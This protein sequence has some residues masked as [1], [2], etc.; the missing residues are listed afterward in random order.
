[1]R[2]RVRKPFL[3][4]IFWGGSWDIIDVGAKGRE[5]LESIHVLVKLDLN[6]ITPR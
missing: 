3:I 2:A 5:T 6:L 4:S 1:M